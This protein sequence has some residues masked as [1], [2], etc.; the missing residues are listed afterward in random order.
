MLDV[1][2]RALRVNQWTKNGIV[3][4]AWFFAVA[5]PSQAA[6]ARGIR[7]FILVAAMAAA[8]SLVSSAFYLLNDVADFD[9]DR[10][11]PVKRNRPVAAGLVSRIAAVRVSLSLF[12]VALMFPCYLVFRHPDRTLGFAVILLYSVMQCAYSGFL[13]RL[14]YVDVVVIAAGFVLRAV[15]GAAAMDVRISPWLLGCAFALS[16]FIAL[17]KRRHELSFAAESRAALSGYHPVA[18]DVLMFASAAA[19]LVVYTWYTLSPD[20][21]ARFG[22]RW[23]VATAV[24]VALGLSRYIGLVYSKADVGRP[25]KILLSDWPMWIILAGYGIS[26]VVAVLMRRV[27]AVDVLV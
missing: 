20:T 8:F 25:E 24:F 5:D 6:M 15:A 17:A 27:A 1:W 4:L 13:K 22:T 21:V 11:H 23:L 7:P 26:A 19:T 12:A 9:A 14:P 2:L 16:L 18:L 3:F 10:L